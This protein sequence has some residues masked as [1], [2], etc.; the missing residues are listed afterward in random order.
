MQRGAGGE[1]DGAASWVE[2]HM[3]GFVGC[4]KNPDTSGWFYS[5]DWTITGTEGDHPG[6]STSSGGEATGVNVGSPFRM[7]GSGHPAWQRC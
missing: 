6:C 3:Q 7:L 1:A 2:A 5:G 4:V